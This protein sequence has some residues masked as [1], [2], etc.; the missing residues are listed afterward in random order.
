MIAKIRG[1][2]ESESVRLI[3]ID[4]PESVARNRPVECYG[5]EASEYTKRLLPV[6]TD[7]MLVLDVEHRDIYDRLLAYVVR[8]EDGLFIN[9]DLAAQGYADVLTYPP[10]TTHEADFEHAKALA[11]ASGKGLWGACGGPDVPLNPD[12]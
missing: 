12:G 1:V 11:K 4:T 2:S 8:V 3:G 9:L 5:K 7:I 10:N 6:G